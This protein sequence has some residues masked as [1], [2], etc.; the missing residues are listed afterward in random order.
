M[1]LEAAYKW[2]GVLIV[3]VYTSICVWLRGA[4][5]VPQVTAVEKPTCSLQAGAPQTFISGWDWTECA[6]GF[7]GEPELLIPVVPTAI[8]S[9]PRTCVF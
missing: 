6:F 7:L 1:F 3:Q 5:Y 4:V 8:F 2:P 9:Q